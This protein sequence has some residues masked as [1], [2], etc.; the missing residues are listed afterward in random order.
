MPWF[1]FFT[2]MSVVE[3]FLLVCLLYRLHKAERFLQHVDRFL[4]DN[5]TCDD[6]RKD[7]SRDAASSRNP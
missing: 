6:C 1:S 7:A 5:F 2:G 4:A 3:A